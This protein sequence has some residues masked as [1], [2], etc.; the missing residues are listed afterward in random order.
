MLPLT[1][2]KYSCPFCSR[3]SWRVKWFTIPTFVYGYISI[4]TATAPP[5]LCVSPKPKHKLSSA[6]VVSVLRR[7]RLE[8][9]RVSSY[10]YYYYYLDRKKNKKN[11]HTLTKK[12]VKTQVKQNIKQQEILQKWINICPYQWVYHQKTQSAVDALWGHYEHPFDWCN[13]MINVCAK[14]LNSKT[15]I[16][17][18]LRYYRRNCRV[19]L[20]LSKWRSD[21]K[22][23]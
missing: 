17:I 7:F 3:R 18:Q 4:L 13:L 14:K 10:A 22:W 23:N 20:I 6:S 8:S 12:T 15:Y 11:T 19:C 16:Y 5:H 9:G 1:D 2:A 21:V